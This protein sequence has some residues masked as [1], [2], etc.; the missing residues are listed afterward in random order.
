MTSLWSEDKV[1]VIGKAGTPVLFDTGVYIVVLG[2]VLT[3]IFSLAE[4]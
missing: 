1:V 2:V 3:I 4:D